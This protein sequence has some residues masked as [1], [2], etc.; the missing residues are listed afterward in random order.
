MQVWLQECSYPEVSQSGCFSK[1]PKELKTSRFPGLWTL[2]NIQIQQTQGGIC[3]SVFSQGPC[4]STKCQYRPEPWVFS[5]HSTTP[6]ALQEKHQ[7]LLVYA[8]ALFFCANRVIL[9]GVGVGHFLE[10]Y[11]PNSVEEKWEYGCQLLEEV[12]DYSWTQDATVWRAVAAQAVLT[13]IPSQETLFSQ[14]LTAYTLQRHRV[15]ALYP[16]IKGTLFPTS[17][18][19]NFLV[20]TLINLVIQIPNTWQMNFSKCKSKGEKPIDS[21]KKLPL[22]TDSQHL[23]L[24]GAVMIITVQMCWE[25]TMTQVL[26]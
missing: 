8:G 15:L 22:T 23:F 9:L 19:C 6:R 1:P 16:E 5:V 17:E 11:T 4:G 14:H 10:L 2:G 18:P 7:F 26:G 20:S 3:Q 24:N 12:S 25:F 21:D 13:L